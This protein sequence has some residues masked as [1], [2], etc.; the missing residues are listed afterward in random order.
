MT[1]TGGLICFVVT[2]PVMAIAIIVVLM[3]GFDINEA[4]IDRISEKQDAIRRD[5]L[6][7]IDAL[8]RIDQ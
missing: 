1:K 4:R 3:A 2:V 8:E 6:R 7:E 5:M